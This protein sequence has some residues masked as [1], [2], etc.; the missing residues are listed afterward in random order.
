[1]SQPK[2]E[3]GRFT[4]W[5]E[6]KIRRWSWTVLVLAIFLVLGMIIGGLIW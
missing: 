2:D 5:H 3:R 1:M 6:W 4:S